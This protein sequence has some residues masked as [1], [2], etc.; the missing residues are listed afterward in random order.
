M[1]ESR[2]SRLSCGRRTENDGAAVFRLVFDQAPFGVRET[3]QGAG[4]E[5]G[6]FYTLSYDAHEGQGFLVF[7]GNGV[8]AGTFLVVLGGKAVA[9]IEAQAQRVALDLIVEVGQHP[10]AFIQGAALAP[11]GCQRRCG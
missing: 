3:D 10:P 8:G 9:I 6:V 1:P 5:A 7:R 11:A 2:P 4:G